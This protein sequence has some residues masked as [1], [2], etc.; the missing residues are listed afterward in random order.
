MLIIPISPQYC[1]TLYME[2]NSTLLQNRILE[3]LHKLGLSSNSKNSK[4]TFPKR[5]K[6]AEKYAKYAKKSSANLQTDKLTT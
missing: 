1:K 4:N 3:R 2:N 6:Y 5:G